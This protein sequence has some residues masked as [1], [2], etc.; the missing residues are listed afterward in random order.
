MT[1]KFINNLFINEI[2]LT[3]SFYKLYENLIS[4]NR[5]S[6]NFFIYS[7][8]MKIKFNTNLLLNYKRLYLKFIEITRRETIE[9]I[10][11]MEAKIN[12]ILIP[13]D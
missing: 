5:K 9:K 10:I 1:R 12:E 7:K 3:K 2:K 8:S 6:C 13:L 4:L 11:V